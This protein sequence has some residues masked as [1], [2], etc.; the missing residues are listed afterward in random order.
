M[1]IST[2]ISWVV[3]IWEILTIII[4][5]GSSDEL[6]NARKN[7]GVQK[8]NSTESLQND[9][10]WNNMAAEQGIITMLLPGL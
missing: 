8:S 7:E 4:L 5:Q 1:Y 2:P 3:D 9:E 10:M 6:L